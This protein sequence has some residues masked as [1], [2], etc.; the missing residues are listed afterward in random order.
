LLDFS[1]VEMELVFVEDD[2]TDVSSFDVA[3]QY[4][5]EGAFTVIDED[6]FIEDGIADEIT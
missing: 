3:F 6:S 2:S 5:G 1:V 4:H